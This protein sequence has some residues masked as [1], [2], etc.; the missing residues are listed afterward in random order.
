[1]LDKVGF[2]EQKEEF[3]VVFGSGDHAP[4]NHLQGKPSIS[5]RSAAKYQSNTE[6]AVNRY[7]RIIE[8]ASNLTLSNYN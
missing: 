4:K 6:E 1:M 2:P 8:Q 5:I 3:I 7:I